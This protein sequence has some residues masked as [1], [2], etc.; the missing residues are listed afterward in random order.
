MF[1]IVTFGECMVRFSTP[2]GVMLEQAERLRAD[3]AG[4]ESNVAV[5]FARLGARS[6]WLSALPDNPIGRWMAERIAAHG[7]DVSHVV[8]THD[9]AGIFFLEAGSPPRGSRVVYDRADSAVSRLTPEMIDWAFVTDTRLLHLS[10][11]TPALSESCRDIV[12]RALTAARARGCMTSFDINYRAKLW[13]PEQAAAVL[14]PML[15]MV[16]ILISTVSDIRL[17]FGFEGS[18]DKMIERVRTRFHNRTVVLTLPEG[19]AVGW[20]KETGLL[21]T[22]AHPVERVDRLGAGDA[23]DAGLLWG[24]LRGDLAGG[25]A[26]GAALASLS[27]AEHGDVTWSTAAEINALTRRNVKDRQ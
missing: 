9:R 1:D 12:V 20:S 11:I 19:G 5:A 18:P 13:S 3:P 10:G 7:V 14:S 26:A 15:G 16:D 21:R 24:L 8:W 2:G 27:H 4:T 23:F 22:G 17:L 6:A 25:L